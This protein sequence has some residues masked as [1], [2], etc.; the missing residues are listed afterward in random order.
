MQLADRI[1]VVDD[2]VQL[3]RSI[4]HGLRDV[5]RSVAE[6]GTG[7]EAIA[8]VERE[9]PE[10]VVLDL[11]LPDVD[12]LEVCRTL[13]ERTV[14][15]IV[16]LSARH[17]EREKVRLLEAGAD[18]YVTKPFSPRELVARV[19]MVLRRVHRPPRVITTGGVEI[20]LTSREVRK[21]GVTVTM[22]PAEFR[23]LEVLASS[24]GRAWTRGTLAERA[25]G[26]EY[27]ALDRTID[28]HIMN[29]RRKLERD[30]AKPRLIQTVFGVGYR[31]C[32]AADDEPRD[33]DGLQA[34]NDRR[35]PRRA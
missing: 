33:P 31:F 2:D 7:G 27:E 5:A 11:G 18:D 30:R 3:R 16:V 6:A 10:L 26:M 12:G 1:L 20:D 32:A 35:G 17:G 24:P 9:P 25:F 22:T 4:A 28:A 15:P 23:L 13:R 8:Y 34:G 19:A 21:D 14:A 29:L